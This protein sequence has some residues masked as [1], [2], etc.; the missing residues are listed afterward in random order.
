MVSKD[1]DF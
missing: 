1:R